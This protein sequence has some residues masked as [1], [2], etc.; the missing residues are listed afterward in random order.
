MVF[1][2]GPRQVCKTT[3]ARD[4]VSK[5]FQHFGYYNWDN[6]QDRRSIMQSNW[7][8]DA[9][10]IIPVSC[11]FDIAFKRLFFADCHPFRRNLAR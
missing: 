5:H 10:L 4:I 3:L 11:G 8:G 7:S 6:R 2:G 9:E 1:I